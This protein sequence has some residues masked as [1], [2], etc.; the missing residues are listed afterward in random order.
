M[1]N[2]EIKSGQEWEYKTRPNETD[3]TLV[4]G[5]LEIHK[6]MGEIVHITVKNVKVRNPSANDGVGKHIQHIPIS[7]ASLEN[8]LTKIKNENEV[9]EGIEQGIQEWRNA[10]GGVFDLSVSEA[11]QCIEDVLISGTVVEE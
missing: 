11:V 8:C 1:K 6:E 4:I 5:Q 3:S 10:E 7:K 9:A 2:A